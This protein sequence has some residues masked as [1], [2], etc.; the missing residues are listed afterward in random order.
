MKHILVEKKGDC[1]YHTWGVRQGQETEVP[2]L[3]GK[4]SCSVRCPGPDS[5][6]CPLEVLLPV[7]N[8]EC[9]QD[10]VCAYVKRITVL[11][12]KLCDRCYS[13]GAGE[14]AGDR[15]FIKSCPIGRNEERTE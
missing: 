9:G 15:C 6:D 11:E 14:H 2:E 8:C 7:K 12:Q 3:C 13:Y 4:K 5:K 10:E 1:P